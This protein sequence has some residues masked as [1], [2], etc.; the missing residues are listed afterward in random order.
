MLKKTVMVAVVAAM[1]TL[2]L[3]GCACSATSDST[4]SSAAK[5]SNSSAASSSTAS[6]SNAVSSLSIGNGSKTVTVENETGSTVSGLAFKASA[7][8]DYADDCTFSGFT[9]TNGMQASISFDPIAAAQSTSG[10]TYDVKLTTTDDS[11]I[12]I[13]QIDLEN[14]SDITFRF[15]D[16]YGYIT[17]LDNNN[18][19]VSTKDQAIEIEK[20]AAETSLPPDAESEGHE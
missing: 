16:G 18:Q 8:S 14:A 17:Y 13:N 19:T 5:S 11:L 6:T 15:E 12:V 10:S 20:K 9:F 2:L 3:T 7:D 4:S 1:M